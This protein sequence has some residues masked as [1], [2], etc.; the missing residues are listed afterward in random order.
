M[1]QF[2]YVVQRNMLKHFT[3]FTFAIT[4]ETEREQR[5]EK[6]SL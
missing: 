3:I 1:I 5:E 4:F 6:K 2:I